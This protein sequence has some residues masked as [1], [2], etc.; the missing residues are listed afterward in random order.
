M[1]FVVTRTSEC[2]DFDTPPCSEAELGSLVSTERVTVDYFKNYGYSSDDWHK[3]GRNHRIEGEYICRDYDEE[4]WFITIYSIDELIGF[5][6][7]N[8]KVVVSIGEDNDPLIEIYD[9]YRE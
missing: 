3:W 1:R 6:K 8:G 2:G 5:V 4:F 7:K 9:D